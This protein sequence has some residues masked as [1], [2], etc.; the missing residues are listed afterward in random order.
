M[1]I[2]IRR[3]TVVLIST[4][5]VLAILGVCLALWMPRFRRFA[6][7]ARSGVTVQG[8][9]VGGLF[10]SEVRDVVLATAARVE[11]QPVEAMYHSETGDIIPEEPG[12]SVDVDRTVQIV[13]EAKRGEEVSL[14]TRLVQPSV[15]AQMLKAVYGVQTNEPAVALAFNV[16]WGEEC[17]PGILDS[18]ASAG[19]K[20]TFFLTGTWVRKFPELT[21]RIAA[22]GHELANHGYE[23]PHP[24]LLSDSELAALITKN[25]DLIRELTGVRTVL[26]APPYG[27]VNQ[28]I[29]AAAARLGYT[30]VMWTVDTIDWQ[31][32]EPTLILER[33]Q[34]RLAGGNIILVHP[35]EPTARALPAVLATLS[36]KG[37]RAVTVS[38]L[39]PMGKP[40]DSR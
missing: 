23:H 21:Q 29:V 12:I 34:R 8:V 7:G 6:H 22:E 36:D 10:G 5:I 2:T 11:R 16:A 32:P 13:M 37:Y 33:S 20:S 18:L 24:E 26:F 27:E 30:T 19:A 31:R 28:K 4:G 35:T 15:T 17:L 25:E 40:M 38:E 9:Q 39:L 3:R 14:L 1:F